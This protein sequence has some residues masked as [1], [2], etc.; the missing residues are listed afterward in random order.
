[1]LGTGID[2][3][4]DTDGFV[5][6]QMLA[7]DPDGDALSWQ[8]TS[9]PQN[10]S[11][12][13]GVFSVPGGGPTTMTYDP[14]NAGWNGTMEWQP[15]PSAQA[16][17]TFLLTC[18]VT[19]NRGGLA[20]T[21]GTERKLVQVTSQGHVIYAFNNQQIHI[22]NADGTGQRIL[23]N[24]NSLTFG[25]NFSLDGTK[26][27]FHSNSSN[28]VPGYNTGGF[29]NLYLMNADGSG[30]RP[31]FPT[32]TMDTQ[33]GILN[34]QG[35]EVMFRSR[36]T[37][38]SP[39]ELQKIALANPNVI[40]HLATLHVDGRASWSA[41]GSK[42]AFDALLGPDAIWTGNADGSGLAQVTTTRNSYFA[43][44]TGAGKALIFVS[45]ILCPDGVFRLHSLDLTTG[46]L[47]LISNDV[48]RELDPCFDPT[49]TQVAVAAQTTPTTSGLILAIFN[50]PGSLI[51]VSRR[52]TMQA[53]N[54]THPQWRP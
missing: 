39:W 51:T 27:V 32:P 41:D 47:A 31:V 48:Y 1:L 14:L 22:V 46:N 6:L 40:I 4:I 13:P 42:I 11:E 18:T 19:D 26:V 34:P 30:I 12:A 9:T 16:G 38:S 35:T 5:T 15:P 20:V 52:L 37:P 25:P 53:G 49:Y 8:W 29:Y 24:T 10:P 21:T 33:E 7:A 54:H 2:A 23:V 28:L 43:Q 45:T 44:Y 3:N 17:D 36:A 50:G